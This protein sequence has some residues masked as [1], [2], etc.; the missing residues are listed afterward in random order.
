MT[1]NSPGWLNKIWGQEKNVSMHG[2]LCQR[3]EVYTI[4]A[5]CLKWI[6]AHK[7][8][9]FELIFGCA[10][11]LQAAQIKKYF[12]RGAQAHTL[13]RLATSTL[14][15]DWNMKFTDTS[16][17]HT[18]PVFFQKNSN[19]IGFLTMVLRCTGH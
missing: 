1:K 15:T 17:K 8:H 4:Q 2:R 18:S 9:V 3:T 16:S 10:C 19:E 12:L 14:L 6:K 7:K 5:G 13:L 11:C